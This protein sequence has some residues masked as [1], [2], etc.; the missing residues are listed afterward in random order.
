[1]TKAQQHL[2][3]LLGQVNTLLDSNMKLNYVLQYGCYKLEAVPRELHF[4]QT[5]IRLIH[6]E[7]GQ[8]P[9]RHIMWN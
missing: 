3:S 4:L 9:L 8:F 2:Q 5:N 1:M 7:I 6:K